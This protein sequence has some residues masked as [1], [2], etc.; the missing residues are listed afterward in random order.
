MD[1]W[2]FLE[3]VWQCQKSKP[4]PSKINLGSGIIL[5]K[6]VLILGKDS[7]INLESIME[8]VLLWSPVKYIIVDD[9]IKFRMRLKLRHNNLHT[10]IVLQKIKVIQSKVHLNSEVGFDNATLKRN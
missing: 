10:K 6:Y 8:E 4:K 1:T 9:H 7:G 3:R 2:V 5:N